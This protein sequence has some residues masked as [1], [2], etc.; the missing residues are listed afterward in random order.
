MNFNIILV[1]LLIAFTS[2]YGDD[3][4]MVKSCEL[5]L[6]N[7]PESAA[8]WNKCR[9][10]G[11]GKWKGIDGL[12]PEHEKSK[13]LKN[14]C[15]YTYGMYDCLVKLKVIN[16]VCIGDEEKAM[17]NYYTKEYGR[18]GCDQ[19]P[20]HSKKCNSAMFVN[21]SPIIIIFSIISCFVQFLKKV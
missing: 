6:Q 5:K 2:V 1:L 21:L 18:R 8:N 17:K 11:E 16:K 9:V 15:C 7:S 4:W 19:F 3:D 13:N 20:Y 10:E 14:Y 12:N